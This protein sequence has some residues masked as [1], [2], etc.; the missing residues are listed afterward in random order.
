MSKK[1][2]SVRAEPQRL[3]YTEACKR[4][5]INEVLSGKLNKRQASQIYGIKG[6][7]TILYWI[8]QSQGLK[9]YEKEARTIANFAEMKQNLHDKK[10]EEENKELEQVV[11]AVRRAAGDLD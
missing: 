5:I 1:Q 4:K 8:R 2:S 10:L 9:G 6:N 3:F 11:A 7:T